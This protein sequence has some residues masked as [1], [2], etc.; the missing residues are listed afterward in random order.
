MKRLDTEVQQKLFD[1]SKCNHLFPEQ[2]SILFWEPL[3]G[4]QSPSPSHMSNT[5]AMV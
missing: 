1:A 4:V 2:G 3:V 5:L